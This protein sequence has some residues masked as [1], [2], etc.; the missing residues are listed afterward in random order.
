[1]QV[2]K[3]IEKLITKSDLELAEFVSELERCGFVHACEGTM[4]YIR[5]TEKEVT[6]GSIHKIHPT[7]KKLPACD[8]S[9]DVPTKIYPSTK[10]SPL[11]CY[12]KY[13]YLGIPV[14]VLLKDWREDVAIPNKKYYLVDELKNI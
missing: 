8:D 1:M 14:F 5:K 12:S 2:H 4:I 10:E 13:W 7:S 9:W 6:V 3:D 11:H